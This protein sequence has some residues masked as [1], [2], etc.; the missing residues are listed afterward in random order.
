MSGLARLLERFS[1]S[2]SMRNDDSPSTAVMRRV[3]WRLVPN[4]DTSRATPEA[5]ST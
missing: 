3:S 2:S 5:R 4:A 1:T